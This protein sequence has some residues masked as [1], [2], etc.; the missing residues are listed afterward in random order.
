MNKNDVIHLAEISKITLADEE[1]QVFA[2]ELCDVI[3]MADE[4]KSF[5]SE[6]LFSSPALNYRQLRADTAYTDKDTPK[7]IKNERQGSFSAPKVM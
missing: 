3:K 7:K 6:L 2:A 4:I 5:D 1:A